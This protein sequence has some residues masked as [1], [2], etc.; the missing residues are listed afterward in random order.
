[1]KKFT[2]YTFGPDVPGFGIFGQEITFNFS[3]NG[4]AIVTQVSKALQKARRLGRFTNM[5]AAIFPLT[6]GPE[7]ESLY[8]NVKKGK[9][10]LLELKGGKNNKPQRFSGDISEKTRATQALLCLADSRWIPRLPLAAIGPI[11]R[12]RGKL[13]PGGVDG[14]YQQMARFPEILEVIL[15]NVVNGDMNLFGKVK[16][17]FNPIT[18]ETRRAVK[19]HNNEDGQFGR[20]LSLS[21][22][23][24]RK[25]R[26]GRMLRD[27][28][29]AQ[30]AARRWWRR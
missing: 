10:T 9:E 28:A 23:R 25:E 29:E 15:E 3:G 4:L 8:E 1:M 19:V 13:G 11:T 20:S 21:L 26:R 17:H 12:P 30:R 18:R 22:G 5:Q 6:P 2:K 27:M 7:F 16:E 14:V 24:S